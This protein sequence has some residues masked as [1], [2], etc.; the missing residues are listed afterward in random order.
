MTQGNK[1]KK[2]IFGL[3]ES[4]SKIVINNNFSYGV[5]PSTNDNT[6]DN[7]DVIII[8]YEEEKD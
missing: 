5:V 2:S 6:E 1:M 3:F 8:T 7:E 4:R